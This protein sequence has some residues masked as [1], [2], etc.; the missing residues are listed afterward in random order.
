MGIIFPFQAL[1]LIWTSSILLFFLLFLNTLPVDLKEV[2]RCLSQRGKE[3]LLTLAL[4][5]LFFPLLTAAAAR[6]FIVDQD[7]AF[8]LVVSS[9]A[10]CALVNPF[11][12]KVRGGDSPLALVNVVVT[13]LI[14]PF[15]TIPILFGLGFD[16][17]YLDL[18]Y[19]VVFLVSLT[20]L[21]IGLS[22]IVARLWPRL[23]TKWSSTLPLCNS[24]ILSALMFVV[25]GSSLNKVP[26]RM[27]QHND[28]LAM[29]LFFIFSDF[30]LY[31]MARYCARLFVQTS[32][33][34]TFALSVSS[35]N[36]A[37]SA[38][39][40][41]FFHPKAALPSAIGLMV[42]AAFFQWLLWKKHAPKLAALIFMSCVGDLSYAQKIRVC[43]PKGQAVMG[44]QH[45][46]EAEEFGFF[47]R[48]GLQVEVA[49]EAGN[50]I[51]AV[52]ASKCQ[53]A[54]AGLDD[55]LKAPPSELKKSLPM[56]EFRRLKG[57]PRLFTVASS[58]IYNARDL[59]NKK[60][61]VGGHEDLA[62]LK[63]LLQG[64]NLN[65]SDVFLEKSGDPYQRLKEQEVDAAFFS[66][67]YAS[68]ARATGTF[69]ALRVARKNQEGDS[70]FVLHSFLAVNLKFAQSFPE[71]IPLIRQAFA[72][73]YS[74]LERNPSRQWAALQRRASRIALPKI[75]LDQKIVENLAV[76]IPN[77][78]FTTLVPTMPNSERE[79]RRQRWQ[80]YLP[81][82]NRDQNSV[83]A[84]L[85]SF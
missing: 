38:S 2:R 6:L 14:C 57:P 64:V 26:L 50:L 56:S 68:V 61:W 16:L 13:T 72:E 37:V 83:P 51:S 11:F 19:T 24:L 53:V 48:L 42:H 39:L 30:G 36:F 29:C 7:F 62:A 34:E 85:D 1:S 32:S 79:I 73:T 21:P 54:I 40:M 25:V 69:R 35:R 58:K 45:A 17:I 80:H 70:S 71:T 76:Q 28:L 60:I 59:K 31:V 66:D 55:L 8:G 74:Y 77:L 5:F 27:L 65:L 49:V 78:S 81:S 44:V 23:P 84:W 41:L 9:L 67:L 47:S 10:P 20:V 75:P 82:E 46:L 63:K 3:S 18:T 22:L 43:I 12:A 15:V 52:G 4:I 33:A